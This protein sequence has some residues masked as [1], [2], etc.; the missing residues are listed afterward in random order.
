MGEDSKISKMDNLKIMLSI[1]ITNL[2]KLYTNY[3]TKF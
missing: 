2:T 1:A 3:Y